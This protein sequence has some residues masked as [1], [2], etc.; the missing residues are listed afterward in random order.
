MMFHVINKRMRLL[1]WFSFSVVHCLGFSPPQTKLVSTDAFPKHK[2]LDEVEDA[3]RNAASIFC[4][5]AAI[6]FTV[7][8]P[9]IAA[10]YGSMSQEQQ[11]VAEAWRLVDR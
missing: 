8:S 5:S 1:S 3:I 11:M 6:T 7:A 2:I 4:V 9:A 10:D